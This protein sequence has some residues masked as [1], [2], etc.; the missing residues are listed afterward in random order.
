MFKIRNYPRV[1]MQGI[2]V[3]AFNVI[4][5]HSQDARVGKMIFKPQCHR[6]LNP[7]CFILTEKL[8]SKSHLITEEGNYLSLK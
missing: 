5:R 2:H 4:S 6:C 3:F 8:R 1:S 7:E